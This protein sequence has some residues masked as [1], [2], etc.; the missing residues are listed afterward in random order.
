MLFK[1]DI[2]WSDSNQ[3]VYVHLTVYDTI[4]VSDIFTPP[5]LPMGLKKTV[6]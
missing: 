1:E 4:T 2:S 6:E 5:P 3:T